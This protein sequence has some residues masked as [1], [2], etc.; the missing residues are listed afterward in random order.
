MNDKDNL[1]QSKKKIGKERRKREQ[2]REVTL[3]PAFSDDWSKVV[4]S[5]M[6]PSF[7]SQSFLRLYMSC[8]MAK[9]FSCGNYNKLHQAHEK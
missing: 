6:V 8:S 4:R 3:E 9:V 7:S 2:N 1:D 5:C